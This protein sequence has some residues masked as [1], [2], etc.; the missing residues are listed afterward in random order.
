MDYPTLHMTIP[1]YGWHVEYYELTEEDSIAFQEAI[2]EEDTYRMKKIL[3]DL[4]KRWDCIDRDGEILC[5]EPGSL[6]KLPSSVLKYLIPNLLLA[7]KETGLCMSPKANASS[8][9][10]THAA[11]GARDGDEIRA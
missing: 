2:E 11:D 1:G 8:S 10:P 6:D 3:I 5:L 7:G 4:I 9:Q